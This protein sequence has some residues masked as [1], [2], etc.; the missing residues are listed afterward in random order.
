MQQT[1][2][3]RQQ[4]QHKAGWEGAP[5]A[6]EVVE[7]RPPQNLQEA[8]MLA[9]EALDGAGPVL[10]PELDAE[11]DDGEHRVGD[12]AYQRR[13]PR[14]VVP[15]VGGGD[16]DGGRSADE[17]ER[18]GGEDVV[19]RLVVQPQDERRDHDREGE[20]DEGTEEVV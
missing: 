17:A 16:H 5:L 12:E 9:R 20:D 19:E 4:P 14:T 11:Q 15:P 10:E 18:L 1:P 8:P 3:K 6:A 2:G 13:R 7:V